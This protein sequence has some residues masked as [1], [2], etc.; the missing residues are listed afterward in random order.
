M[1]LV[2]TSIW[3]EFFNPKSSFLSSQLETLI[4]E[5]QIVTCYPVRAEVLSGTMTEKTKSIITAALEALPA[6]DPDWNAP[7]TWQK[8]IHLAALAHKK[9]TEI[10]GIVDRMLLVTCLESGHILWTLDKKLKRMAGTLE[11]PIFP[12]LGD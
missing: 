3:I 9:K 6:T 8:I 7:E 5:S 11:I 2:D 10:P 12:S 1:I 4:K